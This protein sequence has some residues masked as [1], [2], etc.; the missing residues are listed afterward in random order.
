MKLNQLYYF[1]TVCRYHNITKAAEQLHVSQPA[2]THAVRELEKELGICLFT[3]TNKNV[4]L[5]KEGELFLQKST[6]ILSR[7]EALADEMQDLGELRRAA[8]RV[9]IPSAIGTVIR[10]QLELAAAKEVGVSLEIAEMPPE[11]AEDALYNGELDLLIFRME[12][13]PYPWLEYCI[14]KE[15]CLHFLINKK[16]SMASRE[17]VSIPELQN[18]RLLLLCHEKA[19]ENTFKEFHITPKYVS[20]SDQILTIQ[21]YICAGLASTLEFPE[22]FV[23]NPDIKSVPVTPAVRRNVAVGKKKGRR[24]T[25]A[26]FRFYH[27][28]TEHPEKILI[29]SIV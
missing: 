12:N 26:A 19:A 23:H 3:R 13:K 10:P 4:A 18:E 6:E 7:L 15:T 27:F 2:V 24:L 16:H 5:T 14:L 17:N 20:Y 8:V 22:I 25:A 29:Q 11:E 1:K 28:L 21:R 9:G